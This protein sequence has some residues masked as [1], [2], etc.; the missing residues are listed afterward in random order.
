MIPAKKLHFLMV[1]VYW[2]DIQQ[3]LIWAKESDS[4]QSDT[5]GLIYKSFPVNFSF[6]FCRSKNIEK[7]SLKFW[8]KEYNY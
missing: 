8:K 2:I 1:K 4:Y 3:G 5:V 7:K 6:I